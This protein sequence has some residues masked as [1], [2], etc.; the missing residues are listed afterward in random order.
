MS[1]QIAAALLAVQADLPAVGKPN[2]A[3]TGQYSYRYADLKDVTDTILPTLAD[4]GLVW[5]TMPTVNEN[6]APM[7]HYQLLH[8]SGES[9]EGW[10]PLPSAAGHPQNLGSAI[11]Y[12]RRYAL[13]AVTGL[14]PDVD[15]DAQAA[16]E[17]AKPAETAQD[18]SRL[19]DRARQAQSRDDL[20]TAW[21]EASQSG[22]LKATITDEDGAQGTLEQALTHIAGQLNGGES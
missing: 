2:T 11:T 6:G 4:N 8:I 20:V 14:A 1:E 7:L 22:L 13:C 16:Q 5:T 15:D 3:D 10:Y 17:A 21:R 19:F 12:A 18:A 9:I